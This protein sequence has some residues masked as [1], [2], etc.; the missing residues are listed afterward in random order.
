[1]A[2]GVGATEGFAIELEL[3]LR[4]F[5]VAR[6]RDRSNWDQNVSKYV[7]IRKVAK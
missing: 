4:V 3:A 7:K 1:M 2:K 6:T 5:T